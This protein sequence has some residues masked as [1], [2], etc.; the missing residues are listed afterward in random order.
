[1]DLRKLKESI[2]ANSFKPETL[3][4]VAKDKFLPLMY[5]DV[6]SKKFEIKYINSFNDLPAP[7][8]LFEVKD[9]KS[10]NVFFMEK[11]DFIPD[12]IYNIDNLIMI[13]PNI[14]SETRK[15]CRC[16]II[17]IPE[18]EE[19]QIKD[20]IYSFCL[21]VEESKLEFIFSICSGNVYRIYNECLKLSIFQEN[22]RKHLFNQM[23][24]DNLFD[25]LSSKTIFDFTNAIM[26]KDVKTLE[27]MFEE[28]ENIDINEFGLI[29]VLYNNFS[30]LFKIQLGINATP[31][32]LGIKPGQF[33]AIKRLVGAYSSQ[34][35]IDA[36]KLITDMD[37][38]VKNGEFPVPLMKDYLVTSILSF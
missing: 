32:S 22:E 35:L 31:N 11:V 4:L 12:F 13:I 26:K 16:S 20:L 8:S 3:L 7:N 17:D 24:D 15:L 36:F 28:L 34:Q 21:G 27:V 19:W 2:E 29:T 37:R 10:L 9:D 6:L 5:I 1:M 18:L 30:N 33:N 25:D 23:I 14:D 38:K